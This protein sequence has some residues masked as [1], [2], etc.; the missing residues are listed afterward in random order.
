MKKFA[1]AIVM[2]LVAI[3]TAVPLLTNAG[4]G[5]LS[6]D[7][8]SAC[9]E[10]EV[11]ARAIASSDDPNELKYN[12]QEEYFYFVDGKYPQSYVGNTLNEILKSK[13]TADMSG[14]YTLLIGGVERQVFEYNGEEYMQL[15]L[16]KTTTISLD[17]SNVTFSV[18]GVYYFKLEPIVWRV[19]DY[20]TDISEKPNFYEEVRISNKSIKCV[21]DLVLDYGAITS[22]T[23]SEGWLYTSS[24]MHQYIRNNYTALSDSF[25]YN[26]SLSRSFGYFSSNKQSQVS[27]TS[28]SIAGLVQASQSDC[29]YAGL[30]DLRTKASDLVCVLT[31]VNDSAYCSYSTRDLQNI[32]VGTYVT[33]YGVTSSLWLQSE[34]GVRLAYAYKLEKNGT[35]LKSGVDINEEMKGGVSDYITADTTVEYIIFDYLDENDQYIDPYTGANVVTGRGVDVSKEKNGSILMYRTQT[36]IFIL[37]KYHIVATNLTYAFYM[38]RGLYGIEFN[39]FNTE[40]IN[41][42]GYCFYNCSSLDYLNLEKFDTS[43]VKSTYAMFAGCS[44]LKSIDFSEKFDTSNAT[45]MGNMFYNCTSL[46]ELYGLTLNTTNVKVM[47]SMFYGCESLETFDLSGFDTKN[48]T[49]MQFM[50][51]NCKKLQTLTGMANF[52]TSNVI[53]MSD[54]FAGCYVLDFSFLGQGGEATKFRTPN[55]IDFGSMFYDCRAVETLDLQKFSFDKATDISYMFGKC[56]SLQKILFST[57]NTSK[58]TSMRY[59]FYDCNNLTTFSGLS[60]FNTSSVTDTNRMFAGCHK[61][62]IEYGFMDKVGDLYL[63]MSNVTDMESMFYACLATEKIDLTRFHVAKVINMKYMFGQCVELKTLDFSTFDTQYATDMSYMFY[64]CNKLE[65]LTGMTRFDTS[66]ATTMNRM[67]AGCYKLDLSFLDGVDQIYFNTSNVTD[68]A[69]MFYDCRS[70]VN[71][72][73]SVFRAEKVTDMSSMFAECLELKSIDF[74]SFNPCKTLNMYRMFY[75]CKKLTTMTGMTSFDTSAVTDMNRMFAGCALLDFSFFAGANSFVTSNV[76]DMTSMFYG[77]KA[78]E[79]LDLSRFNT[80]KVTAMGYMFGACSNLKTIYAS[81]NFSVASATV[82]SYMFSGCTNLVGGNGTKFS[83]SYTNKTYARIDKSGQKGYF[84]EFVDCVLFSGKEF[85]KII[86]GGSNYNTLDNMITKIIFKKVSQ[87][88]VG[89]VLVGDAVFATGIGTSTITISSIFDIYAAEDS[90]YMFCTMQSLKS[91]DFSNFNTSKVTN[92]SSMFGYCLNLTSLDLS[93]FDTPKVT[94]LSSMFQQCLNLTSLDLSSFDTSKVTDMS[95]MFFGCSGLKS[96]DLSSFD[97]SNVK[98]LEWMFYNCLSLTSLDL[99]GFDT[100]KV[101]DMGYMFRDCSSLKTIYVSSKWTTASVTSS[102]NMFS[103]CT[104]LKGMMGTAYKSSYVD[105][106]YARL[107]SSSAHG[108]FTYRAAPIGASANMTTGDVSIWYILAIVFVGV[109]AMYLIQFVLMRKNKKN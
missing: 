86:K 27:K 93:S 43:N 32:D 98:S 107:D 19:S 55:V 5:L 7:P 1:F 71:I 46:Q 82:H 95:D 109:F 41:H 67:F 102:S 10:S 91:V 103:G 53:D 69:S 48:V 105:K 99:S 47:S 90:S 30:D 40:Q 77:C 8:D 18:G 92:L 81:D 83:S 97:T 79:V 33:K 29:L 44:S 22:Q 6:G 66:S 36:D 35:E 65:S 101:T 87:T 68:M 39:N 108:Y 13:Y 42:L 80:K 89:G 17:G 45:H 31:G 12:S 26:G 37:S 70:A 16:D 28:S 85:N 96:L 78:V 63:D 4:V 23:T 84:T 50:F 73:M 56:K 21:S 51:Y 34:A 106:T 14:N 58:V 94:N 9:A 64:D 49:K 60:E 11:G 2:S 3:F 88:P 54:M 61:L 57:F 38:M 72:N 20:G 24:E 76:V 25:V 100:S 62:D 52:D 104:S 75:N 15:L 74:T 59:L